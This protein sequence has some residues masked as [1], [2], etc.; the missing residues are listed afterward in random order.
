MLGDVNYDYTK[1]ILGAMSD[2][3]AGTMF[4]CFISIEG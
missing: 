4:V 3:S 1:V 2:N